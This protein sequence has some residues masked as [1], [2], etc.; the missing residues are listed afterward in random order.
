MIVSVHSNSKD[1]PRRPNKKMHKQLD[2]ETVIERKLSI[3]Y[4]NTQKESW[5]II[6]YYKYNIIKY[7]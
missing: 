7:Y 6:Y 2:Y 3:I 1:L 5:D 4:Y